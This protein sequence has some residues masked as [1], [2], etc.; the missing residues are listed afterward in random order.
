MNRTRLRMLMR[1]EV[2]AR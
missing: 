1:R 2:D